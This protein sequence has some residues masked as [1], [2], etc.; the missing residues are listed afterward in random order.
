MHKETLIIKIFSQR[1]HEIKTSSLSVFVLNYKEHPNEVLNG[2][3][4]KYENHVIVV[5]ISRN[6]RSY[7]D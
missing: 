2:H 1:N 3:T 4:V 7:D 5:C 6:I